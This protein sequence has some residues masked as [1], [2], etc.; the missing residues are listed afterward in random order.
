MSDNIP[1]ISRANQEAC[2]AKLRELLDMLDDDVVGFKIIR[3]DGRVT[4][5]IYNGALLKT[6]GWKPFST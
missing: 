6:G 5:T 3:M 2:D 4:V 1:T